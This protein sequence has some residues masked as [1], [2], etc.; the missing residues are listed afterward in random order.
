MDGRQIGRLRMLVTN[1]AASNLP[2]CFTEEVV[3]VE[4][5]STDTIRD[6]TATTVHFLAA[7]RFDCQN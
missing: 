5:P 1:L 4:N 7:K 6:F 2:F 3:K